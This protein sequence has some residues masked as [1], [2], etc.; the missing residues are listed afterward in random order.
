MKEECEIE[1]AT[2][3]EEETPAEG[4]TSHTEEVVEDTI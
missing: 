1:Q 3:V 2:D 4:V